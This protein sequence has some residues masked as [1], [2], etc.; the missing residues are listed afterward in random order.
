MAGERRSK[1]NSICSEKGAKREN[2]KRPKMENGKENKKEKI[3]C[4][5][6]ELGKM[7]CE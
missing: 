4:K 1:R 5:G 7:A 2:G 3:F 6:V